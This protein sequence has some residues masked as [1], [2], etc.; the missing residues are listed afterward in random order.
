MLVSET[1]A[2]KLQEALK[3][4]KQRTGNEWGVYGSTIRGYVE[5]G[6]PGNPQD[7]S[8]AQIDDLLGWHRGT[9]RAVFDGGREAPAV[10]VEA[11]SE[12]GPQEIL[13][14][15]RHLLDDLGRLIGRGA[16]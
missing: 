13:A 8:L 7:K 2:A 11:P 9:S 15:I 10:T 5:K 14:R 12:L 4:H 3:A 1:G 6:F 16:R